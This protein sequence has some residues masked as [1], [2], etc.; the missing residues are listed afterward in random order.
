V[1]DDAAQLVATLERCREELHAVPGV[2]GSGVG[3]QMDKPVIEIYV[4]GRASD[5]I[6]RAIREIADFE[7]VLVPESQ[8]AEAQ[9]P[10]EDG[11]E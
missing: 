1:T 10:D 4:A 7:F 11:K 2:V 5:D 6:E 3:L 8:P 9:A